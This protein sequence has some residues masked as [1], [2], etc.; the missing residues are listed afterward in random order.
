MANNDD[1]QATRGINDAL[2]ACP[3]HDRLAALMCSV[4]SDEPNAR[5]AICDLLSVCGLLA[6]QLPASERLAIGWHM[7]NE[8]ELLNAK[9]N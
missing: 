5:H 6:R 9:W 2:L 7:L 3:M 1:A 8:I 4:V